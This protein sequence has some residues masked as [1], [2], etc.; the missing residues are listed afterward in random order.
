MYTDYEITENT[1]RGWRQE[2]ETFSRFEE[3]IRL[4]QTP[5]DFVRLDDP[6]SV[7]G[8]LI[9]RSIQRVEVK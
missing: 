4:E 2:L 7:P 1:D 5:A 6:D 3:G 9:V 8:I